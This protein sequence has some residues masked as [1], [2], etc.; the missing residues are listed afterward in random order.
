MGGG[1]LDR[2][3]LILGTRRR[4]QSAILSSLP[5]LMG[6]ATLGTPAEAAERGRLGPGSG[7]GGR[8]LSEQWGRGGGGRPLC[9]ALEA[10][11]ELDV[12]LDHEPPG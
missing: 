2:N 10:S 11:K 4:D 5:F 6:P 9:P 8:L 3:V 1:P 7:D 12:P